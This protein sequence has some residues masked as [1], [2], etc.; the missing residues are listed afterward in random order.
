MEPLT[1]KPTFLAI[2]DDYLNNKICEILITKADITADVKTFTVPEEGLKYIAT[3][4]D[5]SATKLTILLLDINMPTMSGWE[6]LAEFEKFDLI[7]KQ[8]FKI[9]IL[10][11][12]IDERDLERAKSNKNVVEY[13]KKPL[14]TDKILE[15]IEQTYSQ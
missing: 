12:S 4:Y 10:S 11:S 5:G 1:N 13:I 6:F 3:A 8:C 7:I 15:I 14:R 2:D 9:Y